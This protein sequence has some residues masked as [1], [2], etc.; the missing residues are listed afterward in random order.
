[1]KLISF[2]ILIKSTLYIFGKPLPKFQR[3]K[4]NKKSLSEN[5]NKNLSKEDD[6]YDSYMILKFKKDLDYPKGFK[7]EYRKDISFII[8]R[9]N[10]SKLKSDAKLNINKIFEI[11][12]HFNKAVKNLRSFFDKDEDKNIFYLASID[13]SNFDSSLVTNLGRMFYGCYSLESINFSNFNTSLVTNMWSMF[14]GCSS[15]KSIDLSTFNTSL[16]K[17]MGFMFNMCNSLTSLNLSNFNTSSVNYMASMLSTCGSLKSIDLSNFDTSRVTDMDW[18]FFSSD[19]LVSLNLSN[20][21]TTLVKSMRTMFGFCS[22]LI[23]IDLSNFNTTLVT[24]MERM[25]YKCDSLKFLDISKFNM[26][27]C[28]LYDEMFSN[29]DSIKFLNLYNF[30]NDKIISKIFSKID[31]LFVCQKTNIINNPKTFNC[32]NYNFEKNECNLNLNID[33]INLDTTNIDTTNIDITNI[34]DISDSPSD[35]IQSSSKINIEAIIGIILGII[36]LI[37]IIT[38]IICMCKNKNKKTQIHTSK[39]SSMTTLPTVIE[40]KIFIFKTTSQYEIQV[41]IETDKTMEQLIKLYFETIEKQYLFG[42]EKIVFIWNA[43]A[44]PHDSKNLIK[45]YFNKRYEGNVI[46]IYDL[47]NKII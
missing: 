9:E 27:N 39:N 37:I 5:E 13:L 26:I 38:V 3:N 30:K 28:V 7:N 40:Q 47:D 20:F 22:S 43:E 8:N 35:F 1:M 12:I 44:I 6:Y 32:C 36:V 45:N 34:S 46:L 4:N 2:L 33:T 31:E 42:D 21:N 41:I 19:S 18:M 15:L 14:N 10:N 29:I 11:E 17:D 16:V 24:N 25:F 23:F